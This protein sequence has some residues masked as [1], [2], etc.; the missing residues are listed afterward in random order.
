MVL[1]SLALKAACLQDA[2]T[3][4]LAVAALAAGALE[5][6]LVTSEQRYR[7]PQTAAAYALSVAAAAVGRGDAAG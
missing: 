5:A 4:A 6:R 2:L 1:A 3:A 7:R